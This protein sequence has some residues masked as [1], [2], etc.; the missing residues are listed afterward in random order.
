MSMTDPIA[1]YLTR[2]RNAIKARKR[3][4]S[5]P[6][7]KMKM[8]ICEVLKR[9]GFITNYSVAEEGAFK[10]LTVELKYNDNNQSA[11]EGLKRISSPGQRIYAKKDEIP[12]V[13][14][15]LGVSIVTTSHGVM[16]DRE[17][18]KNN[19]GGE[20]ICAIW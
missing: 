14:Y 3:T 17:A 10:T 13:R 9:E 12:R 20:I 1:D 19:V 6:S 16:T 2:I 7:S 15:G 4:V 5:M 18:I 11:I 8:H